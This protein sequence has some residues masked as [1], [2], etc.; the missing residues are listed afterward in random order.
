[1]RLVATCSKY[2]HLNDFYC[3]EDSKHRVMKENIVKNYTG[4][5]FIESA[6]CKHQYEA[7]S[8]QTLIFNYYY[9]V[10]QKNK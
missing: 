10:L 5:K 2:F 8:I 3:V 1:M 6:D 7:I 4:I 9:I